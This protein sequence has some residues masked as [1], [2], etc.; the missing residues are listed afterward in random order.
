MQRGDPRL[1]WEYGGKY[2]RSKSR[3]RWFLGGILVAIILIVGCIFFCFG[4]FDFMPVL[5]RP[6]LKSLHVLVGGGIKESSGSKFLMNTFVSIRAAGTSPDEPIQAAFD[7]MQ[8]IESLMSRHIPG[9]D[10]F[11]INQ[12]AGGRPVKISDETFHVIWESIKY[13]DITGGA[14]DISI[15]PLM[16]VW[17]FGATDPSVPEPEQI[18]QARSLV[19]WELIELNSEDVTVRLPLHGMSIDLGGV[20]KG[21]AAQEGARVLREHGISHALIDVGGNIVTIG[22]RPDGEAWQIGIRDPRGKSIENT[23]GPTLYVSDCAIATSGD[24]ER[25]FIYAGKRYHH[26]LHPETGMPA[27]TVQSV[28]VI[29]KDSLYADIL[30]TAVFVMGPDKGMD[31]IE[32]LDGVSAM[33]VTGSGDTLFSAEFGEAS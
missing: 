24:Y 32:A 5:K 27:D 28:T 8:R 4:F 2:G 13:A 9:S 3:R 14:F 11:R 1:K 30:S 18:N 20:A 19:G 25:F 16:D 10:V 33:I 31:L 29:A 17:N 7:E 6:S 21:Y 22:S 23:I 26:I 15:G 12:G